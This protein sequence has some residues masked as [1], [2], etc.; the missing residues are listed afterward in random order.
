MKKDILDNFYNAILFFLIVSIAGFLKIMKLNSHEIIQSVDG[1]TEALVSVSEWL[2]KESVR[3]LS[4]KMS[5]SLIMATFGMCIHG[6]VII[7]S[8]GTMDFRSH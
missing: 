3:C 5:R 1:K 8:K 2:V 7:W 4:T 6:S